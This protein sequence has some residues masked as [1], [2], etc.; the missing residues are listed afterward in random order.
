MTTANGVIVVE[1]TP[2]PEVSGMSLVRIYHLDMPELRGEGGTLHEAADALMRHLM[3]EI[4]AVS[5]PWHRELAERIVVQVRS[6]IAEAHKPAQEPPAG[7]AWW[8]SL[9]DL[10]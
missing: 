2:A 3:D 6:Y 9:D 10:V 1:S 4:A 7:E 8:G 5:D